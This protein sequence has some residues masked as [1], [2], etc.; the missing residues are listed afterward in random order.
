MEALVSR[1]HSIQHWNARKGKGKKCAGIFAE[2]RDAGFAVYFDCFDLTVP[3]ANVALQEA[4]FMWH[5]HRAHEHVE[6]HDVDVYN[7]SV[8]LGH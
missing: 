6:A 8:G 2:A 5:G 7:T 1:F 4:P 3:A